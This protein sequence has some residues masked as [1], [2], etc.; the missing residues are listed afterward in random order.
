MIGDDCPIDMLFICRR[1]SGLDAYDVCP[2]G[3]I[4]SDGKCVTDI[5]DNRQR[6]RERNGEKDSDNE[7]SGEE[8]DNES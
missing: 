8:S 3:T 1:R 5:N 6:E 4:C 7:R 2:V